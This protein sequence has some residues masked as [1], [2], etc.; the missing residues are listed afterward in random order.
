MP[1][2]ETVQEEN[3][4]DKNVTPVNVNENISLQETIAPT[5]PREQ[6]TTYNLP[7]TTQE[8]EVH[9]HP[10]HVTHKKKWGEY[11]LEFLMI[12]LAVTAG[13]FAESYHEYLSEREKEKD[14]MESLIKDLQRDTVF[15]N[16]GFPRKEERIKAIDSVFLFFE[17]NK[18]P[19]EIP[20]YVA[21]QIKRSGWD[22]QYDRSTGTINQLKN[23]GGF[24]LI[25]NKDVADSIAAYDLLWERADFWKQGYISLQQTNYSF[26]EKLL[27]AYDLLPVYRN[28]TISLGS[29]SLGS[30]VRQAF[31]CENKYNLS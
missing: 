25:Q 16:T 11:L 10:H 28:S 3:H 1:D 29:S 18:D 6:L 17:S 24:R 20:G 15:L 31:F 19:H 27:N 30:S 2:I 21:A 26:Q 8:M 7:P 14:Y 5:E 4:Q 23:A 9:K 13:F 12:F 22:R